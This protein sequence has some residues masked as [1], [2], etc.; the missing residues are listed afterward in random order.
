MTSTSHEYEPGDPLESARDKFE[1]AH[2]FL[3]AMMSTYHVPN[4]FR[5]CL[6]GFLQAVYSV[7]D[8]VRSEL[9]RGA[10]KTQFQDWYRTHSELLDGDPVIERL[11]KSRNLVVHRAMLTRT[12]AVTAGWFKNGRVRMALGIGD[13]DPNVPSPAIL[14]W[15]RD[16]DGPFRHHV[17]QHRN[18]IGEEIGVQRSWHI[19]ELCDPGQDVL[20]ACHVAWARMSRYLCAA[21]EFAGLPF[22]ETDE[23]PDVHHPAH[24]DT[25]LETDLD[26]SLPE[27]WGWT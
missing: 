20:D 4:E 11:R 19:D 18:F 27:R 8:H 7:A 14:E 12:S 17:L 2:F 6:N 26:P 25:L 16:P 9:N 22:E 10:A 3:H 21:H 1:E 13:F 23:A 15:V 5:W 24:V